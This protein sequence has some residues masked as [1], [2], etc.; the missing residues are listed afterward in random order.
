MRYV[1]GRQGC[2]QLIVRNHLFRKHITSGNGTH[3][4]CTLYATGHCKV[5]CILSDDGVLL[6]K[7]L[8]HQHLPDRRVF[9]LPLIS[10]KMVFIKSMC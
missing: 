3:W 10:E 6:T 1:R 2:T 4:Q 9:T 8:N 5:R 7:N